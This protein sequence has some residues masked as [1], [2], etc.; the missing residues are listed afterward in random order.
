MKKLL[1]ILF[2]A[3][4]AG[5][6]G[7]YWW[8]ATSSDQPTFATV[9]ATRGDL[10]LSVSATGSLEPVEIVDVGAQIVGSIKSFGPDPDQPGKVVDFNSRVRQG[11][12]L[13][14]LDDAPQKVELKKALANQKLAK[15]EL[16]KAS[17]RHEQAKSVFDRAQRLRGTNSESD[18]ENATAEYKISQAEVETAE[19][20][21]DQ[22]KAAAEQAQINLGYTTI[23]SSVD[24]IVI[25]RRVNVGQ[26][27]VAGLN[28]P[29]L[30]LVAKDLSR[31]RVFAAVN[32]ADIGDVHEGQ[33][34]TFTVDTYRDRKY[35]GKVSQIRLNASKAQNVVTYDVVVDV[36]NTD[37]SL[38][39]YM[40]PKVQFEVSRRSN[41]IQVPN[42]AL[43]WRPTWDQVSP[44]ARA[45]IEPPGTQPKSPWKDNGMEGEESEERVDLGVPTVWVVADDGLVRPIKVQTGLS[46]GL[47]T[48]IKGGD[49]EAGTQVVVKVV[50]EA[51]A[52]FVS[53]FVAKVTKI[54]N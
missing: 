46:D 52:D 1:F 12:V 6:A 50:R 43:R 19:A 37:G 31:M 26:T 8:R 53:S 2:V 18:F 20:K 28:A 39:P 30:F 49:L 35:T 24:G 33:A 54:K 3:A 38:R 14:Q 16:A 7:F 48:E 32:E 22:A 4:L 47:V 5:S 34:A 42:Q 11:T 40:T 27:V 41:V 51:K 13:A 9:P 44:S 45:E 10:L 17:A 15:G 36:D 29:S 23:R 21:V 25:D